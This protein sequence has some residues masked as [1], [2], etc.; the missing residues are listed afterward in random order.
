MTETMTTTTRGKY[1][2][3][4]LIATAT[5][6]PP[7][8]SVE[9]IEMYH[10]RRLM[11]AMFAS[12]SASIVLYSRRLYGLASTRMVKMTR[13]VAPVIRKNIVRLG[14]QAKVV[15]SMTL[16]RKRSPANMRRLSLKTPWKESMRGGV[17]G[18]TRVLFHPCL[19]SSFPLSLVLM[20]QRR[21]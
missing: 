21:G 1:I 8:S 11:R 9:E 17:C 18:S 19:F 16:H 6:T 12:I 4:I 10:E 14:E 3:T 7:E 20:F 5:S 2:N 15:A 13:R